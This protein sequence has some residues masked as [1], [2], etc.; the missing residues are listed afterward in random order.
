MK[1][2]MHHSDRAEVKLLDEMR[3]EIGKDWNNQCYDNHVTGTNIAKEKV[4]KIFI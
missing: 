2:K 3:K 4:P 1:S